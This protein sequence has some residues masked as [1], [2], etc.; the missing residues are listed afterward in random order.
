MDWRRIVF[1]VSVLIGG[2]ASFGVWSFQQFNS[3]FENLAAAYSAITPIVREQLT[4]TP[5]ISVT[6]TS[7]DSTDLP[8]VG[9]GQATSTATTT[10]A[11]AA[12]SQQEGIDPKFKLVFPSNISSVYTGCTYEIS[13]VA[14]TTIRSLEVALI[15]IGTKEAS[16]PIASGLAKKYDIKADF[17]R[18][19]WKVG[20]V[21]PGE[22]YIE[23]SKVNG[24]KTE[25]RSKFLEISKMP[26]GIGEG[27]KT[28]ICRGS[29]GLYL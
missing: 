2:A 10:E 8:Q 1:I 26:A 16:G 14:S 22:Y 11:S 9:A 24:I 17:Q 15:D 20:G 12:S 5:I 27:D 4:A 23:V 25:S 19:D 28:N 18:L 13:W 7:T 3:V 29:G 21:W 6:A